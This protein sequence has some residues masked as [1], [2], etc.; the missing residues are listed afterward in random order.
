MHIGRFP[1]PAIDLYAEYMVLH[2]T[3]M[4]RSAKGDSKPP[5]PTLIKACQRYGVAGMDEAYKEDMRS[6][7]YTKTNHTP[8]EIAMLQD[9]CILDNWMLVRL[10]MA[11]R[12]RIHYFGHRSARV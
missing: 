10:F 1:L 7:A 9:Y 4:V 8:E 6:L 2:N 5:G 12:P 3:E 11:M